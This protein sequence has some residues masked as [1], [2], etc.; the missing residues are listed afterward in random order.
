MDVLVL[1]C[2][3]LWPYLFCYFANLTTDRVL[4]IGDDVYNLNWLEYP[5][6]MQKCLILIIARSHEPIQFTGLQMIE[7]SMEMFGK[8]SYISLFILATAN[9]T[10]IFSIANFDFFFD[11]IALQIRMLL[12]YGF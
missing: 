12:L 11:F 10:R 1:F 4:A 5:V 6:Q 9:F 2:G 7:C 3:L 8:V